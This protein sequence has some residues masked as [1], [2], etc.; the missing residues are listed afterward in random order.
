ME[1]PSELTVEAARPWARPAVTV[2]VIAFLSL[3]GGQLP[4]FSLQANLYVLA[5]GGAMIWLGL[6]HRLPRRPSPRRVGAGVAWWLVPVLLFAFVE[7][8]N[9][10]LGSTSEHPTLS[11]LAD[12]AL[13][14]KVVRS[15]VYFAWLTGF[16]GLVRR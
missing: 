15:A 2:P 7:L 6:S 9:Y 14:D 10:A 1:Q 12:P 3:A 13:D 11:K 4:S 16:W 5:I 8:V